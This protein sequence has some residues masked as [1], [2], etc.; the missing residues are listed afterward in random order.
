MVFL[1]SLLKVRVGIFFFFFLLRPLSW[2]DF[3][4][5]AGGEGGASRVWTTWRWGVGGGWWACSPGWGG[6]ADWLFARP[7]SSPSAQSLP[8][9]PPTLQPG[10]QNCLLEHILLLIFSGG[11]LGQGA[12]SVLANGRCA[13]VSCWCRRPTQ[14]LGGEQ[15]PHLRP[16]PVPLQGKGPEGGGAPGGVTA[17]PCAPRRPPEP[18][19][20]AGWGGCSWARPRSPAP[21]QAPTRPGCLPAQTRETLGRARAPAA[22]RVQLGG[23]VAKRMNLAA[24]GGG[25]GGCG[26]CGCPRG[27]RPGLVPGPRTGPHTSSQPRRLEIKRLTRQ[28]CPSFP[29]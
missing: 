5:G 21:S 11:W 12:L 15:R 3:R 27:Q 25:T 22:W 18:G 13:L 20:G 8:A 7:P 24:A 1:R 9:R 17:Q 29:D 6:R 2:K 28:L 14:D 10:P 26:G 4:G 16:R 23:Q 19:L